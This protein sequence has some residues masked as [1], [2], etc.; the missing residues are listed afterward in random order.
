MKGSSL[1]RY[2]LK[3]ELE[4]L[5]SKKGRGTELISLYIPADKNLDDVMSQ[6]RNEFSQASNIKS[7]RTRKNVTTGIETIMQRIKMIGKV[8]ENGVVIFTGAVAAGAQDKEEV[9]I[10]SPPEPVT[11]YMYR[12]DSEFYTKPLEEMLEEKGVYGLLVLDR[13]EATYGLLKG[14]IL[15]TKLKIGSNVPGKTARGGQSSVRYARLR[16]IAAHE[17]FVRIA[18]HAEEIF[19]NVPDLKGIIIGGSGPTK[20]YFVNEEYLHHELRKKILGVV[21]TS[22]TNEFGLQE[23]LDN[24]KSLFEEMDIN[25]EKKL[26]QKFLEEVVKD[27][28]LAAYGEKEIR[29]YIQIGAVNTLLISEAGPIAKKKELIDEFVKLVTAKSGKVE[30]ISADTEE[31]QQLAAFGGIAAILRYRV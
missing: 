22:Y 10:L 30:I 18:R 14:R 23:L 9:H 16:E 17:F 29:E 1:D 7:K 20:D 3:Q 2:L 12:C 28:G 5:K 26:V 25:R 11:T 24:A 4:E 6:M 21:D 27:K 13:R 15:E 8:P 31:G 19:L